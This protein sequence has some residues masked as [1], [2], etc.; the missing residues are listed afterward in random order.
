MTVRP[1]YL[2]WENSSAGPTLICVV[3]VVIIVVVVVVVMCVCWL[4][5][6][7]GAEVVSFVHL[8][9]VF[10]TCLARVVTVKIP[11]F[12]VHATVVLLC[13]G[14]TA[15]LHIVVGYG[16]LFRLFHLVL[17]SGFGSFM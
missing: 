2:E 14:L 6:W 3:V 13:L 15:C 12:F 8:M 1:I 4:Y 5:M 7:V 9:K 11:I 10:P 17:G 16:S